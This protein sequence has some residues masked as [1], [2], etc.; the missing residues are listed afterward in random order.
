L[1]ASIEGALVAGEASGVWIA[2]TRLEVDVKVELKAFG[3]IGK[4]KQGENGCQL[5]ST[6]PVI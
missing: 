3:F 6:W 1:T 4:T 5:T 2:I